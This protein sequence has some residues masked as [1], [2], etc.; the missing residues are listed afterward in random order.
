[1]YPP[2]KSPMAM[3]GVSFAGLDSRSAS[4]LRELVEIYVTTGEPVG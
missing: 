3:A 1:M 2:P 4:I